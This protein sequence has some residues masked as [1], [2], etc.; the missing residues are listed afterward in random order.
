MKTTYH[1]L[2]QKIKNRLAFIASIGILILPAYSS[3]AQFNNALKLDGTVSYAEVGDSV[4]LH[5]TDAFTIEAWVRPC[6]L[7]GMIVSKQWCSGNQ[8]G[9]YLSLDAGKLK[10]VFDPDGDCSTAPNVYESNN[11]I[12]S[13][14][15]WV[16]VAV[17]H[18]ST[19]VQL[20]VNGVL[21]PGTL[22]GTNSTVYSNKRPFRIGVYEG[23]TG[24]Y[25]VFF[26]GLID[27]V[28]VWNIVRT[29]TQ[30][31]NAMSTTLTGTETG[32]APYYNMDAITSSGQNVI[33]PNHASYT[34]SPL[35]GW[36]QGNSTVPTFVAYNASGICPGFRY[37]EGQEVLEPES[38]SGT[39]VTVVPNPVINAATF[40]FNQQSGQHILEVTN[41]LGALVSR[42]VFTD[43]SLVSFDKK[44]IAA[45]MYVFVITNTDKN[46]LYKGKFVVE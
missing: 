22:S 44:G 30:I 11:V 45:G 6:N 13:V 35:N 41:Q 5:L 29:G 4:T 27:E 16:H 38:V 34:G 26:Q 23:L 33:I 36:T 37:A 25:G 20:Y 18:L 24:N 10:W 14:N 28:R 2:I 9:Y 15:N 40:V 43:G 3:Y 7:T 39:Q 1:L 17:V 21:V 12:A 46:I 19:G 32:L 31:F 42:Q 8:S